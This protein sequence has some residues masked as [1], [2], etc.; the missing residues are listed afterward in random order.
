MGTAASRKK[1][2]NEAKDILY[3]FAPQLDRDII[4][5]KKNLDDA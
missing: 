4:T 2:H 5:S 1:W 3:N